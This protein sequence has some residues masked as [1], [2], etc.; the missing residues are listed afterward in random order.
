MD[1]YFALVA[2]SHERKF[3]TGGKAFSITQV[4]M[5]VENARKND[6]IGSVSIRRVLPK[7]KKG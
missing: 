4:G 6:V 3:L 2:L 1:E 7:V 5:W